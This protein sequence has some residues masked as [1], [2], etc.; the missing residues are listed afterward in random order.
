MIAFS[1]ANPQASGMNNIILENMRRGMKKDGILCSL[2]MRNEHIIFEYYKNKKAE[3]GVHHINSSTK[4]FTSALIGICMKQ[5]L[6][7]DINTP[8]V[9]FFGDVLSNQSDIRKQHITLYHLLTM[10]AGLDWPEFGEWNYFSPMEYSKNIIQFIFDREMEANPGE[11]M[12]YNSGCSHLLSAIIQRVSG[13]TTSK[14]A[15]EHLFTPL[16]I[17]DAHWLSKQNINLGA[18][19]LSMKIQDMLKFGYLYL[20]KGTIKGIE[21]VP[22]NWITESTIPRFLTYPVIG[23]YGYQWWV[24]S[25]SAKEDKE[26][27]FYFAMGLFGQFII[28]VPEYDMVAVFVS[29]NYS[30]TMKPMQ[31]F[32]EYIFK[33]I[34]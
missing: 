18:N 19:G 17:K 21:I 33:S 32:R 6:L 5:G 16:G 26:V 29:E 4:S 25:I 14:F 15:E 23:H 24:S 11:K 9:E 7:Q 22:Q 3:N 30:D 27:Q 8:I 2:V 13:T 12:N 10:S 20:K 28:I 31:Y 1:N 34:N